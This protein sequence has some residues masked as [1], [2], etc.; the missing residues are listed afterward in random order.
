MTASTPRHLILPFASATSEAAQHTLGALQ[1]PHL[2][3]LLAQLQAQPVDEGDEYTLS[4]PHERALAQALGWP[5][6]DGLLPWAAQA[7]QRAGLAPAPGSGWAWVSPTHWHV[8]TE[9]FSL[10][11]PA[12]LQ[13][14]EAASRQAF[15]AIR[16]LFEDDGIRLHWCSPLQWLAEH[17]SLAHLPTASLDRVIG[18]NVDLWLGPPEAARRL[19]RLQ[20]EAQ[21]LLHAHPLNEVREAQGLPVIN[22][23][24]LSGTGACPQAWQEPVDVVVDERLRGPL[25]AEDWAAW[26]DAWQALDAEL[27]PPL[28]AAAKTGQPVVV[29]LCGERHSQAWAPG[30]KPS[31][32]ARWWAKKPQA[33]ALLMAL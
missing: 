28:C 12:E 17:E 33:S 13:L 29:T 1:L 24:W 31:L 3:A 19:R 26:A 15:E 6:Q 32:W 11:N 30:A 14:D 21:M 27:M 20:A 4:P 18:R 23:F 2:E 9:Q 7:A 8:G 5:L 10:V 22:S 16:P 25:L